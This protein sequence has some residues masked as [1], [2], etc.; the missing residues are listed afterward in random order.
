M[1]VKLI[2]YDAACKAISACVRVDEAKAIR[3][4]ALRLQAYARQA[5]NK[6]MEADCLEVKMKAT[7]RLHELIEAQKVLVGLSKGGRPSKTGFSK[8][9]VSLTD[10]GIDKNIAHQARTLGRLT[11][12]Q[13]DAVVKEARD[14]VNRV[15]R[16]AIRVGNIEYARSS[17]RPRTDGGS[18]R[19]IKQMIREGRKFSVIYADPPWDYK[20][21]S[22]KGRERSADRHYSTMDLDEIKALPIWELAGQDCALFC[23]VTWPFMH[24]GLDI[25]KTW[26]FHYSTAA[27]VWVKQNKNGHGIFAGMGHYTQSNSEACIIAT[28]GSPL[29]LHKDVKQIVSAPV[30]THSAKPEEVRRRIERLFDGPYLELFGRKLIDGWTVWGDEVPFEIQQAAE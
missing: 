23:W 6:Q 21:Y 16:S 7:R 4:E 17:R 30:S 14:S 24:I 5:K 13:F 1:T 19:D 28:K 9:P 12:K 25:I 20:T 15:V 22:G 3:D 2:R 18:F 10:A 27:F 29:R 26:G 8:N 11:D